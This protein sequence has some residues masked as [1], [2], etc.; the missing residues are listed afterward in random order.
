[1]RGGDL[2][3]RAQLQAYRFGARFATPARVLAL[4]FTE[5]EYGA[6]LQAEGSDAML[7]AKCV[8]IATG[9]QYRR[10]S[11]EGGRSWTGAV[12]I[13]RLQG[14]KPSFAVAQR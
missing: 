5:G 2:T 1:V 14:G 4:S 6:I 10:L 9:A 11:A 7:R 12:F 8:L 13:T 3:Y